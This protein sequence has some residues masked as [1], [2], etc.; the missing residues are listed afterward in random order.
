MKKHKDRAGD[1]IGGYRLLRFLG[2]GGF[3]EVYYAEHLYLQTPVAVKL[4]VPQGEQ[5]LRDLMR[6]EART[7]A[8]LI[9]PHIISVLDFGFEG[10]TPYLVMAYAPG[11]TLRSL[12]PQG[13][14]LTIQRVAFYVQRM[15][16]ALQFA[17]DHKI[18][19]R[20][21]KPENMLLGPGNELLLSDFGIAVAAHRTESLSTQEAL[22][23]TAYM[24]PEQSAG[25]AQPASDQYSL[26]VCAYEW[27]A[28][29]RPFSGTTALEIA[30]KHQQEPISPLGNANPDAHLGIFPTIEKVIRKA[31]AKDP[32]K[33]FAS[34]KAF[35]DALINA[36]CEESVRQGSTTI[37]YKGHMDYVSTIAWSPNGQWIASGAGDG[38]V[39][40]WDSSTGERVCTY[41]GHTAPVHVVAWSSDSRQLVSGG[42]DHTAQIWAA[43]EGTRRLTYRGH[44]D[45]I[46]ALAW[47][48]DGKRI[49]SASMD[50][51]VQIWDA[52]TGIHHLTYRGHEKVDSDPLMLDA[53]SWSPSGFYL[54]SGGEDA[55]VQ[56]W[57]TA[58]GKQLALLQEQDMVNN[59]VWLQNGT[60]LFCSSH[61]HVRLY[62]A[63]TWTSFLTSPLPHKV[64][65]YSAVPSPDGSLV[66]SGESNKVIRVWRM[67]TGETL[68]T[69]RGHSGS[70][71]RLAWSPDSR[72]IAS[73][74]SREI[75]IWQAQ[76]E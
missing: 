14:T 61:S 10:E 15:A 20:D 68:F 16:Q 6:S 49:A 18:V 73:I 17:H 45:Y 23:T 58:T 38:S 24:A 63:Q 57:D 47:S 48:P 34:V 75:Y 71:S 22:G 7:S 44:T 25:R 56:V 26:A 12:H 62:D 55:T 74:S 50:R 41:L 69:Y 36:T 59:I 28:G 37:V 42:E 60:L 3:G 19:H 21:V 67:D 43:R 72:R 51:T 31:L 76:P 32:R 39:Q 13:T 46:D 65:F 52:V 11:G 9:H 35:A 29:R 53:L 30:L 8:R 64:F 27:L 54:A 2:Q 1:I 5:E 66:A 70:V 40:I 4:L 33:R